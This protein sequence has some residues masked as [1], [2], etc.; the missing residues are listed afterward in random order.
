MIPNIFFHTAAIIQKERNEINSAAERK[1]KFNLNSNFG[2]RQ[3][4][5]GLS[6]PLSHGIDENIQQRR[7]AS[8]GQGF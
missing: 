5:V 2:S 7:L 3:P 1:K 4:L 8:V 6:L